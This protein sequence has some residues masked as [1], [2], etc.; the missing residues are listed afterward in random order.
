MRSVAYP[1]WFLVT[2]RLTTYARVTVRMS[3]LGCVHL[4]GPVVAS[5]V[6]S[7]TRL[8][9]TAD[10]RGDLPA[11]RGPP[12]Q[13]ESSRVSPRGQVPSGLRKQG[14]NTFRNRFGLSALAT[15]SGLRLTSLAVR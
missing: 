12:R 15:K 14:A 8:N 13:R 3:Q 5:A 7:L 1:S 11:H 9:P 2:R 6:G 10:R 4:S